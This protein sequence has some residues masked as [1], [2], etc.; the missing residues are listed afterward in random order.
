MLIAVN[1]AFAQK[2]NTTTTIDKTSVS[3]SDSD[4]SY[5][6][7]ANFNKLK[8]AKVK[9]IIIEALGQPE[10]QIKDY[11]K[12][13]MDSYSINLGQESLQI[14]LNKEEVKG[15][16]YKK[17]SEMGLKVQSAVNHHSNADNEQ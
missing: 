4:Y 5:T 7:N 14:T 10:H 13:G 15:S 16:V 1:T 2:K 17:I 9:A 3:I 12:W 6:M 8:F 11:F